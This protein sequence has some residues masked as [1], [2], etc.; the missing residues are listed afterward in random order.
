LSLPLCD[1]QCELTNENVNNEIL[2]VSDESINDDNILK[3]SLDNK[4]NEQSRKSMIYMG[5]ATA[6]GGALLFGLIYMRR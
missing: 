3:L 4:K 6:V 1:N 2:K 5:A